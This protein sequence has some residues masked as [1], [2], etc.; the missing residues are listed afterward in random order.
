MRPGEI[1]ET[2]AACHA[3]GAAMVHLHVR[4]SEGGHTLSPNAYRKA[5][6]AVR[7][8]LGEALIIQVTSEAVGKYSPDEQM[9]MVRDLE[10]E[11]VSIAIRE[12]LPEESD[13]G[14]FRSFAHWM[15]DKGIMPQWILYSA[16]DVVR[17]Q[18]LKEKGVIPPGP[19]FRLYV[20][21]RYTKDQ[22]SDPNDLL[23]FLQAASGDDPWAI[24]AFGPREAASALTA[25]ALGGHARVGFENN[26]FLP[27]G[28]KAPDNAALVG[29]VAAG[30]NAIGRPLASAE[31]ARA[32]LRGKVT[33]TTPAH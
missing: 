9:K 13:Q 2:A 31:D 8:R 4:N 22:R 15:A 10:P 3:A 14:S 12:L 24:C 16:D 18:D 26:L 5:I 6:A 28:S 33:T 32:I 29:A 30:A 20:L 11:A 25:A 19:S 17:F 7:D 27:D 21:G 23:A 1:A